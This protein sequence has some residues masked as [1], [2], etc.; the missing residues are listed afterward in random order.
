MNYQIIILL[1]SSVRESTAV[2]YILLNNMLTVERRLKSAIVKTIH[3]HTV[4]FNRLFMS[5]LASPFCT[6]R[7][8]CL[9]TN[10]QFPNLNNYRIS[11]NLDIYVT[12][13]VKRHCAADER[14]TEEVDGRR[15]VSGSL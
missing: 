12:I 10:V 8:N 2:E 11:L 3:V 5:P 1:T 7:Y 9:S 4:V 14:R 15:I 6:L 13:G